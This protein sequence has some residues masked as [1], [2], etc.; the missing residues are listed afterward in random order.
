MRFLFFL[1]FS[2]NAYCEFDYRAEVEFRNTKFEKD[3]NSKTNDDQNSFYTRFNTNFE[4]DFYRINIGGFARVDTLDDSR[5]IT[6]L[7]EAYLKFTKNNHSISFGNHVFNW[8]VLEFFHP[9]DNIN[10]RNFDVNAERIERLGLPS[11]LINEEF[12]NS[13]LQL[14]YFLSTVNPIIPKESN[15]NGFGLNLE[16]PIYINPS[17]DKIDTTNYSQY[18]I[19]YHHT[20]DNI[21][22]DLHWLRKVGNNHAYIGIPIQVIT[23]PNQI[24]V[25]PIYFP[26]TQTGLTLQYVKDDFIFKLESMYFDFD[27]L[28]K[29]VLK[30]IEIFPGFKEE[31]LRPIDHNLNAIG[32]EYT[33]YFTNSHEGTFLVEY[34]F[35]LNTTFD[36][37]KRL[38]AF[39]RDVSIGYRHNFNDFNSNAT[40]FAIIH[41]IQTGDETL[42]NI[43]HSF[44]F[45]ENYK[46]FFN[47]RII[48]APKV[49][50]LFE[51]TGLRPLREADNLSIALTRYF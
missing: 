32:M 34:Q 12:E 18:G 40:I 23:D 28:S 48:D 14:I 5:K 43:E 30:P 9:I 8:S 10:S 21:D 33:K 4:K 26:V 17:S 35:L 1:L 16:N 25:A 2:F 20:F 24:E 51:A 46:M 22:L 47:L 37:A 41:D 11:I 15:R 45:K 27:D 42:Y 38:N 44:R 3:Q 6:N 31:S 39:Q 7:D 50:S 29:T 19:R 49:K 36:Q 13:Y